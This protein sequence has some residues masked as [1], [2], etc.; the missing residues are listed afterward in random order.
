MSWINKHRN[1]LE[2]GL[3]SIMA[4]QGTVTAATS[5]FMSPEQFVCILG[6]M[7]CIDKVDYYLGRI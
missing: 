5:A 1:A 2:A 6:T 4:L 3:Y 7:Y